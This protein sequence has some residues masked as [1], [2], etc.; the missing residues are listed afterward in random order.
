[1]TC[2]TCTHWTP[3]KSGP[4]ASHRMA[5]CSL[6]NRWTYFPPQHGCGKHLEASEQVVAARV[7]WVQT[8]LNVL[9]KGG[10]CE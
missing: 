7:Q 2:K 1:M 10:D 6:G 5:L 3:K 9:K 4:M 8:W